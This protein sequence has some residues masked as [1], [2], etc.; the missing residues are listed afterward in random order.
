MPLTT[1]AITATFKTNPVAL[2]ELLKDC[3]RGDMQLR[4]GVYRDHVREKGALLD[5]GDE[6]AAAIEA[7][8]A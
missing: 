7:L 1:Y 6:E 5:D 2:S 4:A 3:A 8:A